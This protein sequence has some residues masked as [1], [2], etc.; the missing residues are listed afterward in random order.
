MQVA[1]V[2]VGRARQLDGKYFEGKTGIFKEPAAGSVTVGEL[3]LAN[4]EI[5]HS[6]HHGGPDQA[7]YL[8]R[9]EDYD[10]WSETMGHPIHAGTFGENLTLRGLP[11]ADITVGARLRFPTLELEVSAPRIPCKILAQ[12]RTFARRAHRHPHAGEMAG[13]TLE[14]ELICRR[15]INCALQALHPGAAAEAGL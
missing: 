3:G 1:R 9:Q 4:D 14:A 11:A 6:K 8:Y 5:I 12:T 2:N 13:A 10:W 7:V 15:R